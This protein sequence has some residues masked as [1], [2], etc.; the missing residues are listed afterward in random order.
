MTRNIPCHLIPSSESPNSRCCAAHFR[1]HRNRLRDYTAQYVHYCT[2]ISALS[3]FNGPPLETLSQ[4]K[5]HAL[6]CGCPHSAQTGMAL[7]AAMRHR[8]GTGAAIADAGTSD[9]QAN[10]GHRHRR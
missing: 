8:T 4:S 2:R 5:I 6:S 7:A 1:H 3:C 10:N 9:P